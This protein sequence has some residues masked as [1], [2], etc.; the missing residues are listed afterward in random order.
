MGFWTKLSASIEKRNSLLCV[1]LDPHPGQIPDGY[2]S[3]SEF[4]RA[5]VEQTADLACIFKPNIAFYEA[6]GIEGMETLREILEA[7]PDD[8]P[9]LLDGKRNDIGSTATAYAQGV[10]EQLGADALTVNPYL[11]SDGVAPFMAYEDR[12]IFVL[13][14]TSNPGAGEIQDWSQHGVPLYRHVAELA[15]EWAQGKE[16]GLVMGATYPQEMAE[17]RAEFPNTWFLVPGVG[18]Q[19]GDLEAV[20]A[21]GLRADGQGMIINS[22]RGIIYAENPRQAALETRDA[23]NRGRASARVQLAVAAVRET[24]LGRLAK[25]LYDTNCI[26]LGDFVL[27][28]G[29][30]SPIYVDLRR[31]VSDPRVLELAALEYQ[32]LLAPLSYERIAA[33]PYAG[34]PIGTAVSLLTGD[35]LIYPRREA[36]TYGTRRQIEGEYQ[37]GDRVVLVDDLISSGGSK[38]EAAEPLQEAGLSVEDVVVLIDREQGGAADLAA[39]GLRLHAA[40]TLREI[41]GALV[42]QG[43]LDRETQLRVEEYLNGQ[44]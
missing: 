10:F 35:P 30:H 42:V 31:L 3:V 40:Y 13:C 21:A 44:S 34:L 24:R 1:G 29:A 19:G 39:H 33:I 15:S 22:S 2:G 12:G 5:V 25:A 26:Q 8:M 20:L 6:M 23:I 36:K 7:I 32:R 18:A 11:G 16:I 4:M 14:K 27:H 38:L 37:A 41:V 9:V 28:S 17:I 43:K